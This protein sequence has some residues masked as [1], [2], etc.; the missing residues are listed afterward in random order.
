MKALLI[1]FAVGLIVGVVY[2]VI[3]VKSPRRLSLLYSDC[4]GWCQA[5]KREDGFL[6]RKS[7]LHT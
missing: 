7:K 2:G 3:R 6:Q 5:S 1:S 4:S